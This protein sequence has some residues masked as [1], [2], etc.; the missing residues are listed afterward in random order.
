MLFLKIFGTIVGVYAG[1]NLGRVAMAWLK[2]LFELIKPDNF[3]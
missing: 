1:V 3:R 2:E